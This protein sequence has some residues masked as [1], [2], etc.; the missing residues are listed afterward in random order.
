M[1][2]PERVT[3]SPAAFASPEA[4]QAWLVR[5][6]QELADWT[7]D[8]F[9]L[10]FCRIEEAYDRFP[11]IEL[12]RPRR[13][14]L[15]S[16]RHAAAALPQGD[17]LRLLLLCAAADPFD[18][19]ALAT[20]FESAARHE[21]GGA[22][23]EIV[24][25]FRGCPAAGWEELAPAWSALVESAAED[26]VKVA[27]AIEIIEADLPRE[28]LEEI[29]RVIRPGL[30]HA[31]AGTEDAAP[32]LR[33]LAGARRHLAAAA[34]EL[35]DRRPDPE[36]LAI[37]SRL[38]GRLAPPISGVPETPSAWPTGDLSL[39]AF[40]AQWP[41][42][43]LEIPAR[44]LYTSYASLDRDGVLRASRH[45]GK[46][47]CYGP[48]LNLPAGRYRVE[49]IG[50][51]GPGADYTVAVTRLVVEDPS[52]AALQRIQRNSA[53]TGSIAELSFDSAIELTQ[54][55]VN[56][57]VASPEVEFSIAAIRITA[58]RLRQDLD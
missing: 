15:R 8:R 38:R 22:L 6:P 7:P 52:P 56:V 13:A 20:L 50:A 27:A 4:A 24:R 25:L 45:A 39:P 40:L 43:A 44:R 18:P 33:G 23:P 17:A 11:E 54:F 5:V 46:N 41:D 35:D 30:S 51:A 3:A 55:E 42:L 48:Y 14:V 9:P 49:V 26:R 37:A 34:M 58:D 1:P 16:L 10:L 21:G 19:A 57:T 32:R 47:F 28:A 2:E 53:V 29:W 12:A 31:N 36:L